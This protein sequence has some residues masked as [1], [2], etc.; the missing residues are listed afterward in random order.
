VVQPL[1]NEGR[2]DEMGERGNLR[3]QDLPKDDINEGIWNTPKALGETGSSAFL[4]M[5]VVRG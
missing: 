3:T 5:Y 2:G 1:R 4:G